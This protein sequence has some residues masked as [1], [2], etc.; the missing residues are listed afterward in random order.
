VTVPRNA[1]T[2]PPFIDS[3]I[4]ITPLGPRSALIPRSS[5]TKK[6]WRR[7]R[8][9]HLAVPGNEIGRKNGWP[10]RRRVG[11]VFVAET[12]LAGGYNFRPV[13]FLFSAGQTNP[14]SFTPAFRRNVT[15]LWR[16]EPLGGD[17]HFNTPIPLFGGNAA[18]ENPPALSARSHSPAY[19]PA[20]S[21]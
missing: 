15:F 13:F 3:A 8:P 10:A 14:Y 12:A 6:R 20:H 4:T 18:F 9:D 19:Q 21:L 2:G 1:V 5:Q 17:L 7:A 16:S 11:L